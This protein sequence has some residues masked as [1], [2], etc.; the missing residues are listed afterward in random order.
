ML[1][2]RV[3]LV[4]FK[5]LYRG[6]FLFYLITE[7]IASCAPPEFSTRIVIV[8][9]GASGIAAATKLMLNGFRN[10]KILEA[11]NRIGG[12]VN[13]VKFGESRLSRNRSIDN[14][15]FAFYR[16]LLGRFGR[17]M[18]PRRKGERRIR[19]RGRYEPD[20]SLGTVQERSIHIIG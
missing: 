16:R 14:S 12:R 6:I 8:G 13:T 15:L 18:G 2:F 20:R 17:A 1:A 7:T 9:S 11:E 4:S 3:Q 19:N 5:M 10:V